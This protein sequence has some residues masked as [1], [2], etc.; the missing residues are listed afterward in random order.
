MSVK[1]KGGKEL[2][3]HLFFFAGFSL[4]QTTQLVNV[5]FTYKLIHCI[6]VPQLTNKDGQTNAEIKCSRLKGLY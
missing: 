3:N 1:N 6:V 4:P 2:Q 5:V